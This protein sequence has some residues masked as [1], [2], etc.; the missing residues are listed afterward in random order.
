MTLWLTI[1]VIVQRMPDLISTRHSSRGTLQILCPAQ[2]PDFLATS[3]LGLPLMSNRPF[4]LLAIMFFLASLLTGIA[5][6][7]KAAQVAKFAAVASSV[8]GDDD[9]LVFRR[10]SR[11]FLA[12]YREVAITSLAVLVAGVVA[13]IVSCRRRE[14]GLQS[15]PLLLMIFAVFIQFLMV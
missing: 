3:P 2:M 5:A 1:L 6:Q 12:D 4:Y 9:R 10:L 14:S 11:R 8:D 7:T 13:W 15:I